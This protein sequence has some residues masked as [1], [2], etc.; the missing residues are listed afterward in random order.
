MC[1][2]A[3]VDAIILH[4]S[5]LDEFLKRQKVTKENLFRYLNERKISVPNTDKAALEMQIKGLMSGGS[6]Q[7]SQSPSAHSIVKQNLLTPGTSWTV[8]EPSYNPSNLTMTLP[9]SQPQFPEFQMPGAAQVCQFPSLCF[10]VNSLALSG[11]S[12]L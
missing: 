8:P 4:S 3:C 11:R 7:L 5:S 12:I 10:F 6:G 9:P 2:S 1:V